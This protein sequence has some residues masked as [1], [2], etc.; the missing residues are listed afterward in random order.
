MSR[1]TLKTKHPDRYRH[2][3][4][5]TGSLW[6]YDLDGDRWGPSYRLYIFRDSAE[7]M[8][9][10]GS[11]QEFRET[12]LER[13]GFVL[14]SRVIY[15]DET[16]MSSAMEMP[17]RVSCSYQ[18]WACSRCGVWYLAL[19]MIRPREDLERDA[20]TGRDYFV[21]H[22]AVHPRGDGRTRPQDASSLMC[23]GKIY[24]IECAKIS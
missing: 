23:R 20:D 22:M 16:H 8:W 4:G 5:R 3:D 19:E 15:E 21:C 6:A 10:L 9:V 18:V 1:W 11:A 12:I 17:R 13:E 14:V 24:H 2:P 7:G